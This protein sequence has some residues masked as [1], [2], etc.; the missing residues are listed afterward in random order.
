MILA[1]R[2][3]H[4]QCP[5]QNNWP[6]VSPCSDVESNGLHILGADPQR[7]DLD[8][9][10]GRRLYRDKP[11]FRGGTG[12]KGEQEEKSR[13]GGPREEQEAVGCG[14]FHSKGYRYSEGMHGHWWSTARG[15]RIVARSYTARMDVSVG[16]LRL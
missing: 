16:C 13:E 7:A 14:G 11:D 8:K 2:R 5:P 15:C 10:V 3:H 4:T 1:C 6:I 12:D 9:P